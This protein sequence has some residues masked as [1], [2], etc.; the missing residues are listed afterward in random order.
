M[1]NVLGLYSLVLGTPIN[2]G[3]RVTMGGK[4]ARTIFFEMGG[5]SPMGVILSFDNLES[6]SGLLRYHTRYD[7]I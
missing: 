2:D 7:H 5:T 4:W 3:G 1:W 6:K